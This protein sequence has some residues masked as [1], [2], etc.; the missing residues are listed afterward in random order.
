MMQSIESSRIVVN[1][2]IQL[3]CFTIHT[4][5]PTMIEMLIQILIYLIIAGLIWWAVNTIIGVIPL[6]EPIKTVVYVVMVVIL[7]LIVLYAL[8]PLVSHIPRVR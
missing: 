4:K 7:V 5:E 1:T 8:M 2:S 6:P 3:P